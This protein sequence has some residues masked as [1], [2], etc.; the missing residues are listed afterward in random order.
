M[1]FAVESLSV[2]FW[3]LS[4]IPVAPWLL[5]TNVEEADHQTIYCFDVYISNNCIIEIEIEILLNISN[6]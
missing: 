1:Y 3:S 4:I 6:N 5:E 2:Y